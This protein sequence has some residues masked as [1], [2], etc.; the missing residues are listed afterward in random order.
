MPLTELLG[1]LWHV[2][3]FLCVGG[4]F[5]K[6]TDFDNP[7]SLVKKKWKSLYV[8]LLVFYAIFIMLHNWFFNI[9]FY[10]T[11]ALYVGKHI[12]PYNNFVDYVRACGFGLL[13]ARE[14][15][16]GAM[17]FINLMFLGFIIIAILIFAFN[18]FKVS[19]DRRFSLL[20]FALFAL[21]IV[22][23]I[24]T[25]VCDIHIL[26]ATPAV[27][28][29]WLLII[30]YVLNNRIKLQYNNKY[31]F[32]MSLLLMYE[33]SCVFGCI[34]LADDIFYSLVILSVATLSSLYV[35][36]FIAKRI[37]NTFVGRVLNICGNESYYIMALHLFGFKFATLFLNSV[38][39]TKP[40]DA[41]HSPATCIWEWILYTLFG[42]VIPI[43]IS[44]SI[45]KILYRVKK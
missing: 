13:A 3:V 34:S 35:L 26:R 5:V 42:V 23:S 22:N 39:I 38:G 9:G 28:A 2:P 10:S 27:N 7:C 18:K 19:G 21:A 32:I 40:L 4:F 24:I 14:P 29:S 15:L 44:I 43:V 41:G 45:K 30:G 17:W 20:G 36:G 1:T 16:L 11:D 37:Q 25:Q 8:K 31:I 33:I 12:T 6:D